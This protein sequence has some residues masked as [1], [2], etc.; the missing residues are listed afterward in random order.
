MQWDT[1]WDKRVAGDTQGYSHSH[2]TRTGAAGSRR[3]FP[4]DSA[5]MWTARQAVGRSSSRDPDDPEFVD[6]DLVDYA[7][8]PRNWAGDPWEA[9]PHHQAGLVGLVVPIVSA[10][11]EG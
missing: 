6:L 2:Y 5:C 3:G 1:D 11:C 10:R 7:W 8:W 9:E 4:L